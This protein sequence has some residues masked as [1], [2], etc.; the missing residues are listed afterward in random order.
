MDLKEFQNL[1]EAEV[2]K[3]KLSTPAMLNLLYEKVQDDLKFLAAEIKTLKLNMREVQE[4]GIRYLGIYQR[5]LIYNKGDIV[6]YGGSMWACLSDNT[7]EK[8]GNCSSWQ[9]CVKGTR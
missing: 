7:S 9:L 1:P 6:T 4:G 8:P 5:A 3:L 2:K